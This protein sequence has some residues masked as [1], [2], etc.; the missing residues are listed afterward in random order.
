MNPMQNKINQLM[1]RLNAQR[2][3]LA[4]V[5]SLKMHVE[6]LRVYNENKDD[7]I[8]NL[9]LQI[10]TLT[11]TNKS[12]N[13]KLE[14][15][16]WKQEKAAAEFAEQIQQYIYIYY[17]NNRARKTPSS[18]S[19][20]RTNKKR[21]SSSSSLSSQSQTHSYR[22]IEGLLY[23]IKPEKISINNYLSLPSLLPSLTFYLPHIFTQTKSFQIIFCK[24]LYYYI[25]YMNM[26]E[27]LNH[28]HIQKF[29]DTM[30]IYKLIIIK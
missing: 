14:I 13:K 25:Y 5:S 22:L 26:K 28:I 2:S 10:K 29:L 20:N 4:T 19:S 18:S 1:S 3:L 15:Q 17:N 27:K 11:Q 12:L 30:Y 24:F 9:K 16:K 21:I 23:C 8:E 7:E 6:E